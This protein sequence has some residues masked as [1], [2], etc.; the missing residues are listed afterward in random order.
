MSSRKGVSRLTL[1]LLIDAIIIV[2]LMALLRNYVND[3]VGEVEV[4]RFVNNISPNIQIR[5]TDV[6]VVKIPE[7]GVGENVIRADQ[8]V[9]GLFANQKI[10][11]GELVD[12][13]K[14]VKSQQA[15]PLA[16]VSETEIK[17]LRKITIPV[18]IISTWGG[19][20]S[21]G[22]R[23][24]LAF[25]GEIESKDGSKGGSYAKVFMQ[26]VLVYD[27][28]TSSGDSYI[29]PEDRQPVEIDTSVEESAE[30]A[31]KEIALRKDIKMVILAVT[32]EQYE[33][34]LA[35]QEKGKISVVGRFEG[36]E[37]Y[38]TNGFAFGEVDEPVKMG[39]TKIES[40][41]TEIVNNEK[42][43]EGSW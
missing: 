43:T 37:S 14:V 10:Y 21:R 34:I 2:I 29:K 40:K 11:K 35:R 5:S 6:E 39:Q 20:I 30:L 32:V 22:D 9:V 27:V 23:V 7:K 25:T 31:E 17:K 28:L 12:S 15:N 1:F 13:R 33:E 36:S 19:A 38:E 3:K 16:F 18:D 24:D 41:K 4:Y 8:E 26:N 42:Q